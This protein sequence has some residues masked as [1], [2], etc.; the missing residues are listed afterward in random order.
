MAALQ[1]AATVHTVGIAKA[2]II[3]EPPF[4][5]TSD[6]SLRHPAV[7]FE[8]CAHRGAKLVEVGPEGGGD[9]SER[10]MD[11]VGRCCRGEG[12]RPDTNLRGG[13]HDPR[14]HVRSEGL[15]VLDAN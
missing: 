14:S 5:R 11:F 8:E 10:S 12:L 1:P 15:R 9:L 4:R 6:N 2:V 7:E 13:L 3:L